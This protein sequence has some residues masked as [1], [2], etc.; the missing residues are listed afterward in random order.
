MPP[1]EPEVEVGATSQAVA[2]SW[3]STDRFVPR[4]VVRPLQR[5][6]AVETSSAALIL[7]VTVA[8]LIVANTPL[9]GTYERF[10]ESH[11]TLELAEL[12]ILDLTLH[13]LVND[14]LM[15]LFFLL[16]S[17][18]IKREMVF[19]ELRDPRAAALPISAAVGGMVAPALIYLAFNLGR[20][21]AGGWGIPMATDIAFA[22]A[23]LTSL[24]SRVPLGARLFLLTLAI[25]DDLGAIL[26]IALFYSGGISF[27]WLIA[28]AATVAAAVLLTRI[29]VRALWVFIVLGSV[30]WFALHE[31]GV[32]A[33]II[34]VAFGLITPAYALLSPKSY[35]E[36]ASSLVEE[37]VV[38]N[39][40]GTVTG[41]EHE[42]NHHSLREIRRLS[43]ET[44][45]PL[46]RVETRLAPYVAFGI[47]PLFAFANAGLPF[48][49]V[50]VTEWA[51]DPVV[52]GVFLGL[53]VGKTVGIFAAG[54]LTVRS[55]LAR[56][57]SGMTQA[58]LLGVSITAGIGFT[59]AIFVA[60]LAFQDANTIELAKLGIMLGSLV[61]ALAGYAVLRLSSRP[62]RE[63]AT[64]S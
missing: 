42:L 54:W 41:D 33:T 57:P 27:G 17:L 29:R 3:R 37:V 47:V 12:H 23:L 39:E 44:Q 5:L 34:G 52:L 8:A 45:S 35:P 61:A 2:R 46:H 38:R 19:G 51:T 13:E 7:L 14:G 26:V 21:S 16:V 58:H 64:R 53:V 10:W 50:P 1:A 31:S 6:M 59:V 43:L 18:E 55:G 28:A 32:H 15:T 11:L 48:P 9:L 60:D 25:V 4:V 56:Y 62:I 49:D 24:G 30:G 36:V 20:P 40:D 63:E 22:V